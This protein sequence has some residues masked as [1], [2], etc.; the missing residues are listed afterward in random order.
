MFAITISNVTYRIPDTHIAFANAHKDIV[1][2]YHGDIAWIKKFTRENTPG[3]IDERWE[4]DKS[5]NLV[6]VTERVL[7]E[8]E[9]LRAEEE[10]RQAHLRQA[11]LARK[12]NSRYDTLYD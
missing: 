4:L 3:T 9:I 11:L 5:G 8:Q 10:L 12:R 7:A 1:R 6:N 2:A